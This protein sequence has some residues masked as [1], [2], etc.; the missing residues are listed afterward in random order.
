MNHDI[1]VLQVAAS[2]GKIEGVPTLV[3]FDGFVDSIISVV[4]KRHAPNEFTRIETIADFGAAVSAAAGKS[5]NFE[6]VVDQT[7]IGGNGPIM[8]LAL[9][10][11]QTP[12][13]YCGAIASD[14]LATSVHPVFGRLADLA[15]DCI[16]SGPPAGTDAL[17]FRDVNDVKL[18]PMSAVTW[19]KLDAAVGDGLP[20][21]HT[22]R[23]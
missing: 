3:G 8:A 9:A 5:R 22:F 18:G 17:E 4:D 1:E 15:S 19:D 13:T 21:W 16:L 23:H 20:R 6:L 7:K 2:V 10:E 11:A 14:E 12:V